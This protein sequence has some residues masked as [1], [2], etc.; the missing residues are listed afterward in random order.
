[1][2]DEDIVDFCRRHRPGVGIVGILPESAVAAS[3]PA[4]IRYRKE[5]LSGVSD[6]FSFGFVTQSSRFLKKGFKL[7]TGGMNQP[8]SFSNRQGGR[9]HTSL[10]GKRCITT[11]L[12]LRTSFLASPHR[13]GAEVHL[14]FHG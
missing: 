10:R 2:T 1:S 5:D 3:V 11:T 7:R 12:P 13:R 8:I 4:E 9:H 14:R 6:C